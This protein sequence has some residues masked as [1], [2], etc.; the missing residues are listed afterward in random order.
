MPSSAGLPTVDS[1]GGGIGSHAGAVVVQLDGP[2]TTA[3][4]R[5]E[6]V[7][8]IAANPRVV[9]RAA[10]AATRANAGR[11]ANG[12]LEKLSLGDAPDGWLCAGAC[13]LDIPDK[14]GCSISG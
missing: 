13:F 9:Q 5:G 14:Q 4:L 3:L 11:R 2:A 7:E 1:I 6:A 10:M 8:T 12:H